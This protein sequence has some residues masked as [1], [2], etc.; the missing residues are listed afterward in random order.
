MIFR[1]LKQTIK[2]LSVGLLCQSLDY[3]LTIYLFSKNVDLFYSNLLG[4]FIATLISYI[5]HSKYTFKNKSKHLLNINQ[6]LLFILACFVGSIFG[7]CVLKLMLIFQINI[8]FSKLMQ[9]A[10]IA[11]IQYYLNSRITFKKR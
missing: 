4:Y 1:E 9:L 7:Y 11:I 6:I 3:I 8:K 2:Y 5:C 10:I